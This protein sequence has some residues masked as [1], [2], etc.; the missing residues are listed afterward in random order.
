MICVM[1]INP[2][3]QLVGIFGYP[4]SDS[5]FSSPG[6]DM[7]DIPYVLACPLLLKVTRALS[8][9]RCN[10]MKH[11]GICQHNFNT[12]SHCSPRLT[13][14]CVAWINGWPSSRAFERSRE[15][16]VTSQWP[17]ARCRPWKIL[18]WRLSLKN[19]PLSALKVSHTIVNSCLWYDNSSAGIH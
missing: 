6:R 13:S 11:V 1:S 17:T 2:I 8:H 19:L 9:K 7:L 10:F 16:S 4:T 12:F 3:A 14:L 15:W 5:V 18:C